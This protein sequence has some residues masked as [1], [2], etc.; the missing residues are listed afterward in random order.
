MEGA[1]NIRFLGFIA[2]SAAACLADSGAWAAVTV[3]G[4]GA[5]PSCYQFAEF[6]GNTSDGITTCEFA[7]E[8]T[9]LSV[10]DRAATFVNRGILRARKNESEGALADL[11]RETRSIR[12][13]G[14]ALS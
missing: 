7:L 13:R 5:A 2:I 3:L 10:R 4:N 9:T 8:Q 14:E 1:M 11:N 6:V 12:A